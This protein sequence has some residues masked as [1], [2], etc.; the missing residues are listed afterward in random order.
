MRWTLFYVQAYYWY[1]LVPKKLNHD[2][3]STQFKSLIYELISKPQSFISLHLHLLCR[4]NYT[5]YVYGILIGSRSTP[6]CTCGLTT[7]FK[8]FPLK[9]HWNPIPSDFITLGGNSLKRVGGGGGCI[10]S[11]LLPSLSLRETMFHRQEMWNSHPNLYDTC[12]HAE[13]CAIVKRPNGI[14]KEY[15]G[16]TQVI[17]T[18]AKVRYKFCTLAPEMDIVTSISFSLVLLW[19]WGRTL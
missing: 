15:I 7:F 3:G 19:W 14:N 12:F 13:V 6:I 4:D 5:R 8:I 2:S 18:V 1:R 9:M 11:H 17:A 16:K 10:H